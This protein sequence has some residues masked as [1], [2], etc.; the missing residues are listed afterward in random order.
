MRHWSLIGGCSHAVLVA[1]QVSEVH[2]SPSSG[3]LTPAPAGD[4]ALVLVPVVHT[5]QTFVGS[6][7]VSA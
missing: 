7:A 6:A 4:Q 1:E 3:Q 2:D 5:A